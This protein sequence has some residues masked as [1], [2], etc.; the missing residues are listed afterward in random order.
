MVINPRLDAKFIAT[1]TNCEGESI[2]FTD[3]ST[4]PAG[5]AIPSSSYKWNFGDGESSTLVSPTHTYKKYGT[6]NV[7]LSIS[8]ST[9]C[10]ASALQQLTV[11]PKPVADFSYSTIRCSGT[12]VTFTDRSYLTTGFNGFI[13]SWTWDFGDGSKPVTFNY[14]ST[15]PNVVH[16]FSAGAFSYKVR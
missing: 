10:S 8:N 9:G 6:Y 15:S 3:A 16:T 2:S 1:T 13:N 12:P 7:T 5:T 14:P 11:T 4:T